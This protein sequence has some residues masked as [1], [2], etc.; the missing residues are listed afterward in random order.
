MYEANIHVFLHYEL[1]Y[2]C[3][4]MLVYIYINCNK[5]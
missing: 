3:N 1:C 4:D 5:L 2:I